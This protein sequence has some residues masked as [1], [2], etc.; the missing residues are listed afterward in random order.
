MGHKSVLLVDDE[1]GFR[2]AVSQV[3]QYRGYDVVAV[4]G[5]QEALTWCATNRTSIGAVL[6]DVCMP[7][8]GGPE[9]AAEI[10]RRHPDL[11]VVLM[12]GCHAHRHGRPKSP[13]IQKPFRTD[14]LVRLLDSAL[15]SGLVAQ[16]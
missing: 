6:A 2:E 13:F 4:G 16:A 7:S 14:E 10:S 12:S 5:A 3:L 15:Q 8:M 11:P 9:L 1:Q